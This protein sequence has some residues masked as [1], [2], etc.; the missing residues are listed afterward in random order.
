M[1][2]AYV[3]FK[4]SLDGTHA[5]EYTVG[6]QYERVQGLRGLR[7]ITGAWVVTGRVTE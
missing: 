6:A 3:S 7:S 5:L 4:A 2:L 1:T